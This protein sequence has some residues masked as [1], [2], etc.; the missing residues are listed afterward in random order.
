M[1]IKKTINEDSAEAFEILKLHFEK[2]FGRKIELTK[3]QHSF[4]SH[5]NLFRFKMD[6]PGTVA[7]L[8]I[9]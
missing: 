9:P 8:M 1:E 7:I 6:A 4:D 2:V 5:K 3:Y